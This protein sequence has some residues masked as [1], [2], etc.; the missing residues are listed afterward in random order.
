MNN[1]FLVVIGSGLTAAIV[2][3]C[4][5]SGAGSNSQDNERA[6]Q[7]LAAQVPKKVDAATTLV[8]VRSDGQ[9]GVI[10][11]NAVDTS[12]VSVPSTQN[13]KHMLCDVGPDSPPAGN[14]NTFSGITYIYLD[15]QG[16]EL[17][18]LRLGRGECPGQAL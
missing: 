6:I 3:G 11:V 2:V 7:A 15:L 18:N 14:R 4:A 10:Y 17:A 13:L 5:P 1:R 12:M 8:E 16:H 9:G